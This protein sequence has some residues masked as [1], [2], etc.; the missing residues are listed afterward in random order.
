ME[1]IKKR[2]PEQFFRANR[3]FIINIDAV[4]RVNN[5]FNGKL[6]VKTKPESEEKIIVSRE[7]AR[8]FRNW[9]DR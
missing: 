7:R 2:I 4:N 3:Q 8:F 5:W 9:L 1:S 6:V